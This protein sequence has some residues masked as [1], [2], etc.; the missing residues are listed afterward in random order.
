MADIRWTGGANAVTQV[1]TVTIAGTW[2]SSKICTFTIGNKDYVH[3]ATSSTISVI[4]AAIVAEFNLLNLPEFAEITAVDAS[5]DIVFTVDKTGYPITMTVTEDAD[6]TAVLVATTAATGPN[7]GN[8]ED[9]WKDS[10]GVKGVPIATDNLIFENGNID[11]LYGL[12]HSSIALAGLEVRQSY[13]G[14]IGL[15]EQNTDTTD[16]TA[17][18]ALDQTTYLEYRPRVFDID[19]AL[20]TIGE[21][22]GE[23]SPLIR[24]DLNTRNT[25]LLVVNSGQAIDDFSHAVMVIS[26]TATNNFRVVKGD[27][28]FAT[29][30]GEACTITNLDIGYVDNI[31]TD[32]TVEC[33]NGVVLTNVVKQGGNFQTY[34]DITTTF[35]HTGG[36]A[37]IHNSVTLTMNTLSI[38]GG[39]VNCR[40]VGTIAKLNIGSDSTLTR[41]GATEALTITAS[42]VFTGATI[43][44]ANKTVTWT[45]D[46]QL[47][48]CGLPDVDLDLGDHLQVGIATI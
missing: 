40:G 21:G 17:R 48:R 14:Q 19:S 45:N 43:L 3:T 2:A 7:F 1:D 12:D 24:L 39:T 42:D 25:T 11:L 26:G 35:D 34:A 6:G 8:N 41:T 37:T 10:S 27:V 23:G 22:E 33:G 32:A 47:Q 36:T 46:L 38:D 13:T 15:P 29:F 31:D 28:G 20:V 4:V 44:D 30:G 9:N 18:A 16:L 5:P